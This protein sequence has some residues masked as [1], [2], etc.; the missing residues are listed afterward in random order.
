MTQI[1]LTERD[2]ALLSRMYKLTML[3]KEEILNLTQLFKINEILTYALGGITLREKKIIEMH[4]SGMTLSACGLQE[5]V[6]SERIRQIEVKGLRK[7][8]IF[9]RRT[10]IV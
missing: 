7:I 1:T 5:G 3:T 6:T 8:V 9:L 4:I 2:I 10:Y